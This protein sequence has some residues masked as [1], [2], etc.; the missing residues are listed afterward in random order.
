MADVEEVLAKSWREQGVKCMFCTSHSSGLCFVA[1]DANG[2]HLHT[3]V[4]CSKRILKR[5]FDV[6]DDD[7]DSS[8][9]ELYLEWS[10]ATKIQTCKICQEFIR[11]GFWE[12]WLKAKSDT[13]GKQYTACK[14]CAFI[15][16]RTP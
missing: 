7:D 4:M 5:V 2:N 13:G 1:F 8:S 3:T 14:K 9:N 11:P 10:Q 6:S 16:L 15:K 12:S